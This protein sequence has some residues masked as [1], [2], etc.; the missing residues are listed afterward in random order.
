MDVLQLF[1][2]RHLSAV[3]KLASIR[4]KPSQVFV[5]LKPEVE[6]KVDRSVVNLL[7]IGLPAREFRK[8]YG[9][10]FSSDLNE[11]GPDGVTETLV[12]KVLNNRSEVVSEEV[13]AVAGIE[14][15]ICQ[16]IDRVFA[17]NHELNS[18]CRCKAS[19]FIAWKQE[20]ALR[21]SDQA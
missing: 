6:G 21:H 15:C 2:E 11:L 9:S 20:V 14:A 10:D 17:V 16:Q 12:S 3:H 8:T 7:S 4:P 1:V 13:E 18:Q 5:W 19:H